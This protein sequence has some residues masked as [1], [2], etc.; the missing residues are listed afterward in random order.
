MLLSFPENGR[1]QFFLRYCVSEK[2]EMIY[3]SH[4]KY[5]LIYFI[6]TIQ[7]NITKDKTYVQ[8]LR[9]CSLG[10]PLYIICFKWN[11][12]IKILG[13]FLFSKIII[14]V[15][16]NFFFFFFFWEAKERGATWA[17]III[18]ILI[19]IG[20]HNWRYLMCFRSIP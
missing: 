15:Y 10:S 19:K 6:K 20:L 12:I 1:D 3:F 17:S 5:N 9:Y 13:S 8:Y 16:Y 2:N 14:T 4:L 7:H 18:L 11:S